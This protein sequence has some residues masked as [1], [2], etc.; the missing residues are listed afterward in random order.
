MSRPSVD[1]VV[2]STLVALGLQGRAFTARAVGLDR[3]SSLL[4]ASDGTELVV[5][6]TLL[7]WTEPAVCIGRYGQ[8]ASDKA[9]RYWVI[10][11]NFEEALRREEVD[12]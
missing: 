9:R 11:G 8:H 5:V 6:P 3:Y 7:G 4:I 2:V 12:A 10:R 1:D